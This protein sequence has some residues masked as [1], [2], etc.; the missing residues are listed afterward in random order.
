MGGFIANV[1]LFIAADSGVMH[2]AS[3]SGTPTLG[4]FSVSEESVY[5]PY[6]HKSF[7]VNTEQTDNEEIVNLISKTLR[8]YSID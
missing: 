5:Q 2:L 4:L 6:N 1:A 7:S 8:E 3:A